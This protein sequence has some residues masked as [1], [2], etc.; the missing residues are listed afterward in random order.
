[1]EASGEAVVAQHVVPDPFELHETGEWRARRDALRI[2]RSAHPI[3]ETR[4]DEHGH[5]RRAP[6]R[7]QIEPLELLEIRDVAPEH[8]ASR[9]RRPL[10]NAQ[11]R[12]ELEDL[13]GRESASEDPRVHLR[14]CR[15]VRREVLVVG[16]TREESLSARTVDDALTPLSRRCPENRDRG[17]AARPSAEERRH[18][19][20][21]ALTEEDRR[22]DVVLRAKGIE[23]SAVS[24]YLREEIRLRRGW[25]LAV[26]GSR[27]LHA[28][29]RE[30]Q[31]RERFDEL[32]SRILWVGAELARSMAET[33]EHE[34][35][36]ERRLEIE[37]HG[38]DRAQARYTIDRRHVSEPHRR[39][40]DLFDRRG[41]HRALEDVRDAG[42]LHEKHD[43]CSRPKLTS[44][45]RELSAVLDGFT[46]DR[47]KH[48]TGQDPRNV[49][50]RPG[51]HMQDL[52][53]RS[54][55][56]EAERPSSRELPF[57]LIH[58]VLT[59]A[60]RADVLHACVDD[61]RHGT[62]SAIED[63]A[64]RL[65]R[66]VRFVRESDLEDALPEIEVLICGSAPKVDWSG[67]AKLR[68]VHFLG[69]G[70]DGFF[71]ARGLREEV[72]VANARGIHAH[73]MRDHTL[74]MILAFERD[75][76]GTIARQTE[77][78]WERRQIGSVFGKTVLVLGLGEVG[79]PIARACA[80]LGMHVIG[81]CARPRP[82][83]GTSE[84]AG[85]EALHAKLAIADYVVVAL[86]LTKKT[87]HLL[88]RVAL[89]Q[90]KDG[91]A[92]IVISRGGIVDEAAL[93][94]ALTSGRLRSAALDVFAEEPLPGSSP[95]WTAP[96]L[97]V[98]PHI[99]GWMP[100]YVERAL[101]VVAE[102][103]VRVEA[104]VEVTT[105][106]DREREY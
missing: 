99:A 32:P 84:V 20:A 14:P 45:A 85:I 102:N 93:L 89:A 75:L 79:R 42:A 25:A 21:H 61:T 87:E 74:A 11:V 3:V 49:R 103:L 40:A 68:L 38:R 59:M 55:K 26:A 81:I 23:R 60:W 72:I 98:T 48:I 54:T 35:G 76:L 80:L 33:R 69:T 58:C 18:H 106:V 8:R 6:K 65:G 95:L 27:S 16:H 1:M 82:I 41:E 9:A 56:L 57:V 5:V 92:L 53:A 71:P 46:V 64:Q 105:P 13:F 37:R 7:R 17:H 90:L 73:E 97:I 100:G 94:D 70:V 4:E 39:A 10:E 30:P 67:G 31:R 101:A 34:H 43:G 86:T 36:D 2:L 47:R 29:G 15:H 62:Q 104:G 63:V 12:R 88:D 19:A 96:N 91:A 66:K 44:D 52:E 24:L 78:R 22:L 77:R 28:N 50:R 83:E 51:H